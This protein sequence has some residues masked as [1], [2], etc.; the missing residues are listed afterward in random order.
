MKNIIDQRI[1]KI[2]DLLK[3]ESET[4]MVAVKTEQGVNWNGVTYPDEKALDKAI[5][6]IYG[7]NAGKSL[8][9]INII[10]CEKETQ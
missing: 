8:V 2:E 9:I 1:R 5:E 6:T 10:H 4:C 7:R 3:S